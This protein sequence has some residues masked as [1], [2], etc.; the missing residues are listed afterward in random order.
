MNLADSELMGGIL[1]QDGYSAAPSLEESDVILI[2]TCAVREKAEERVFGRLSHLLR[3]KHENPDLILGVTGCM[4]NHLKKDITE[5]A[6]Y[7]DLVIG[8]DAY[9]RL[10]QLIQRAQDEEVDPLI[11][12]K[13]DK[14]ETYDGLMPHREEG[15][16]AWIT[17]QRGCDKF[18]TF[19]VVPFTRGRERGVA[20]PDIVAQARNCAERGFKEITLLG[21]TVNSYRWEDKDFADLLEELVTVEGIDRIRFTSPYPTDFTPKLMETMAAH[22]KICNYLHLPAQSG[23]NDV[24]ERMKRQYTREEFD[25]LVERIRETVPGIAMSTDIIVGFPGETDEDFERTLDLMR[26][27]R[28]DFGYLFKYSE[29]SLTAAARNIPDD[30]PEEVKGARLRQLI[31]LQEEISGEIFQGRIGT[32]Q[33]VLVFGDSRRDENQLC[34]RTDDFKM[35]VFDKEPG[36]EIGPG[37]LVE[38]TIEDATSHTLI[39]KI[40]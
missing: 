30:V 5:R 25:E 35:C 37:D 17:V 23:S 4:A 1:S 20:I 9:R 39:G 22:K 36:R 33:E 21:Q 12:V 8:P 2:N 16:N 14:R 15:I 32:T 6:P 3:F 24:L 38:V 13:L 27:T 28:F 18:C 31:E 34:G 7:V 29:R 40:A 19:C 10:P 26:K 11:D